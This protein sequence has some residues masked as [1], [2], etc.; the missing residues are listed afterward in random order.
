[1]NRFVNI[2]AV[3]SGQQVP[4][5]R[6]GTPPLGQ[7]G[8]M[9]LNERALAQN[10]K[11]KT[12]GNTTSANIER[13]APYTS[14]RFNGPN[15]YSNTQYQQAGYGQ[16]IDETQR[17]TQYHKD[18]LEDTTV[19]SDFDRTKSDIVIDPGY[20]HHGEDERGYTQQVFSHPDEQANVYPNHRTFDDYAGAKEP[21]I[22]QH[23][24]SRS[25]LVN[26][27]P[28]PVSQR[29]QS[30]APATRFEGKKLHQDLQLR[31]GYDQVSKKRSRSRDMARAPAPRVPVA[32]SDSP[33]EDDDADDLDFPNDPLDAT[34]RLDR[35]QINNHVSSDN[36][37]ASPTRRLKSRTFPQSQSSQ[38]QPLVEDEVQGGDVVD[39][40]L[41]PD[42]TIEELKRMKYSDLESE[43]WDM[44]PYAKPFE[45]PNELQGRKVTLEK[46][47]TYYATKVTEEDD[48]IPF[49]E[50]LTTEEWDQAGD[51]FIEKFGELM[52]RLKAKKQEKRKA[53]EGF[54]D[55]IRDREKAVRNEAGKID[56][57]LEDMEITGKSLLPPPMRRSHR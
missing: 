25:P 50:S 40:R 43:G 30:L 53:A 32:E 52:K 18:V 35:N 47:V 48:Q 15:G 31:S 28:E 7:T 26:T 17:D 46:K 16:E 21:H 1:M 10:L 24:Q 36:E 57:C 5:E 37:G 3:Q 41:I 11:M 6:N 33:E 56:K 42:Y 12:S 20:K 23:K 49:Y 54:E 39:V 34:V 55:E 38:N 45:L 22:I 44:V 14:N 29:Q 8:T 2:R 19:A 51:L 4:S 27:K 9:A 13:A